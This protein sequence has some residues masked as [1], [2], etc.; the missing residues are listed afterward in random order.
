[1]GTLYCRFL[2]QRR[3]ANQRERLTR[4]LLDA[5]HDLW[6]AIEDWIDRRRFR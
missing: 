6:L 5:L 4:R 3:H 2:Q 1:M